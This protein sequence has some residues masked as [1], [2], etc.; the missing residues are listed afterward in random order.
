M[1][2]VNMTY[3]KTRF[4]IDLQ[5]WLALLLSVVLLSCSEERI[6]T[7]QTGTDELSL[8]MT[9]HAP[10]TRLP[11]TRSGEL[12][13]ESFIRE[14]KVL[15]FTA[16]NGRYIFRYATEGTG[17]QRPTETITRFTA[18]LRS[19][20]NIPTKLL[21]LTNANNEVDDQ[22]PR[23]GIDDEETVRKQLSRAVTTDGLSDP[24]P[25]F[26][27]YLLPDGINASAPPVNISVRIL[28]S[29]AR[30]DVINQDETGNFILE[31]VQIFRANDRMQLMP[32]ELVTYLDDQGSE[33]IRVDEPSIAEGTQIMPVTT[34]F[35]SLAVNGQQSSVGQL[36]LPEAMAPEVGN[37]VTQAT[38]I[39]AGGQYQGSGDRKYYYRI[40][41]RP[42]GYPLGE[43]LRNHRYEFQ[44]KSVRTPGWET[45]EEA[46]QNSST[47]MEVTVAEWDDFT[48]DMYWDNDHYY[49]V[50]TRHIHL[51]YRAGAMA[52]IDVHTDLTGDLL[53]WVDAEGNPL[54]NDP[55]SP[56]LE[57]QR[58]R[59]SMI[60]EAGSDT[61]IH[62]KILVEAKEENNTTADYSEYMM[63]HVNRWKIFITITQLRRKNSNEIIRVLST[64]EIGNMGH[65]GNV[66]TGP[67]PFVNA[68]SNYSRA[69]R[70]ILDNHFGPGLTV[71]IQGINYTLVS[72]AQNSIDAALTNE[73][74]AQQDIVF[75]T[76]N[77]RPN[78]ATAQRI[79]DWLNARPN[80]V[81][82]LGFDWKDAGINFNT[83]TTPE[84]ATTTNYNVL[85]LL[86][87]DVFM[88]W[89]NGGSNNAIGDYA[90]NRED[91]ITAMDLTAESEY[92]W[93][94]G[95]FT[96]DNEVESATYWIE[97]VY[98][99]RADIRN[100][101]IIPLISYRDAFRDDGVQFPIGDSRRGDGRM[102]MG[103]DPVRR[104][105]YIGDCQFFSARDIGSN[106][107]KRASRIDN[108]QGQV[109]NGYARIMANLW[110]WMIEEVVLGN[111]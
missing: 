93:R 42:D 7:P 61:L 12:P 13:A 91:F 97:D 81:L 35:P 70:A 3:R 55:L 23:P 96:I 8:L 83:T 107:Y 21:I 43:I 17:L 72:P 24:F 98:W 2:K 51:Q 31:T 76:N 65:N 11:A 57:S 62:K 67:P 85:R 59:V 110:A 106:V 22:Y 80:R 49:G 103:V 90:G 39:V 56:G 100:P 4:R 68:S 1:E 25:M 29:I 105:V 86:Q 104:I 34:P 53:Q 101:N 47:Q 10:A 108:E 75:L 19:S 5:V 50:S 78:R 89:Y 69:M 84:A 16:E 95:P 52:T 37:Q 88:N 82:M 9:I 20:T 54:N 71:D 77:N 41:F 111:N 94:T 48:T 87:D 33:R 28:R 73:V 44:I 45:P 6:I 63:I 102:I 18:L 27:E 38:C 64:N 66:I 15:V 99:G 109:N 58:F 60:Q 92:F 79:L 26:G 32:D 36:Y 40:D 14:V 74:L 46:A 30:A